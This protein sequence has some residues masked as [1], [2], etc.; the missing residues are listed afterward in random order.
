MFCYIFK[1][2]SSVETLF[3]TG[4]DVL[5]KATFIKKWYLRSPLQQFLSKS[6]SISITT[7]WFLVSSRTN[8]PHNGRQQW[9]SCAGSTE[10]MC[11]VTRRIPARMRFLQQHTPA[12]EEAGKCGRSSGPWTVWIWTMDT[13]GWSGVSDGPCMTLAQLETLCVKHLQWHVREGQTVLLYVRSILSTKIAVDNFQLLCPSW[14]VNAFSIL[15]W[16][17]VR[18]IFSS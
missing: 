14:S 11:R 10:S 17:M 7:D 4:Y 2:V 15:C 16:S 1:R 6:E 18:K 8:Y 13:R 3:T 9:S 12:G 5:K